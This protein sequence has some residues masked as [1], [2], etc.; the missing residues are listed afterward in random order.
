MLK[1]FKIY[2]REY[3]GT[4]MTVQHFESIEYRPYE[5][6]NDFPVVALQGDI[7]RLSDVPS[8]RLHFHNCLEIGLCKDGQSHMIL[9]SKEIT[10]HAG[11]VTCIG[12]DIVHTTWSE[13]GTKALWSYLF[14]DLEQLFAGSGDLS[15]ELW[16]QD[17]FYKMQ[18]VYCAVLPQKKH[19]GI[20]DLV[21]TILNEF[22]WNC[23]NYELAVRSFFLAFTVH[24]MNYY[25]RRPVSGKFSDTAHQNPVSIMPALTYMRSHSAEDFP[26]D[27]LADI[28]HISPASFRRAFSSI[29]HTTPLNY[30]IQLRIHNASTLLQ[31]TNMPIISIAQEVG[32]HSISSFNRNFYSTMHMRPNECRKAL[33][34]KDTSAQVRSLVGWTAPE[35]L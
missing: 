27:M 21:Q 8:S 29:M 7:W 14:V 30:L 18:H 34:S 25:H 9:G 15:S 35:D 2:E 12:S 11:D 3:Y 6:R 33:R 19:P 32:F 22:I 10:I 13:K 26:I 5:L 4:Y 1:Y 28:C 31:T 17:V 24:I 16:S 20:V 23:N